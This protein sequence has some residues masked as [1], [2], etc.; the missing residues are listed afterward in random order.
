MNNY[1]EE[2][3]LELPKM[4]TGFYEYI[5]KESISFPILDPRIADSKTKIEQKEQQI[6]FAF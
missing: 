3:Q 4:E 2:K 1:K 6:C 5:T